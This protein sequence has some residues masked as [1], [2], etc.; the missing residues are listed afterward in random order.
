LATGG[1]LAGTWELAS[2]TLA[3]FEESDWLAG[4]WELAS[5]TLANFEESDWLDIYIAAGWELA[6][7]H[8][9]AGV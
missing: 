5:L 7:L 3:N 9:G 8:V 2:L 4:T 1:W 6:S